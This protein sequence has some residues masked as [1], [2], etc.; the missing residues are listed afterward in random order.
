M[1]DFYEISD[2]N[3]YSTT[4]F[5]DVYPNY[6]LFLEGIN[7]EGD[8][9]IGYNTIP[10]FKILKD[11]N[12]LKTIYYLLMGRYG[13]SPIANN[14]VNQFSIKLFSTIFQYGPSWEKRLDIQ[15][16]LRSLTEEEL[17]TGAKS[18]YNHALNPITE[19]TTNTLNE[20]EYINDQ[21]V[22]KYVKA[23]PTAYLELWEILKDDVTE[24][25]LRKFQHLFL[26]I[27]RP[28]RNIYYGTEERKNESRYN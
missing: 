19:P 13:N 22:S 5:S 20:L 8:T 18:I 11:V 15:N 7:Y 25:F 2:I 3:G 6:D 14:D 24:R 28:T 10:E 4:S 27:A 21:N 1:T 12:N 17:L 16:K 23:K 9:I 26:Q